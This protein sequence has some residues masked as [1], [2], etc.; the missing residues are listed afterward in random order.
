MFLLKLFVFCGINNT[1]EIGGKVWK[2]IEIKRCL[3]YL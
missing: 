3:Q 2:I 1:N